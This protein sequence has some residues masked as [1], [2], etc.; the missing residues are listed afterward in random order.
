VALAWLAFAGVELVWKAASA[1]WKKGA[2][3]GL[4]AGFLLAV[5]RPSMGESGV[6]F[7]GSGN[8]RSRKDCAGFDFGLGGIDEDEEMLSVLLGLV[9]LGDGRWPDGCWC[10]SVWVP[11]LIRDVVDRNLLD[12]GSSKWGL[13]MNGRM[14]KEMVV[15]CV[16]E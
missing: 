8:R 5:R 4:E 10:L 9:N 15:L 1:R 7:L 11:L 6:G 12:S 14:I 16:C 3:E 2:I 13:S